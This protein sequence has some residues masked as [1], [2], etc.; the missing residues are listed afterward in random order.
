M[1]LE[2]I[3]TQTLKGALEKYFQPTSENL[4]LISR[5]NFTNMTKIFFLGKKTNR[6]YNSEQHEKDE[7][8]ENLLPTNTY[9]EM[10]DNGIQR[11]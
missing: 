10:T 6:I 8:E 4:Y 7:E 9:L 11:K 5:N 2:N 1:D 3:K